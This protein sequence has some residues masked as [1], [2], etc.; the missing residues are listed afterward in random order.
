MA[1]KRKDAAENIKLRQPDRSGPTDQTLLQLAQEQDLFR[2]A[3]QQ[4]AQIRKTKIKTK[5]RKSGAEN[6][7]DDDDDDED[8]QDA[9]GL[10]PIAERIMDSVLWTVSLAMLHFT[11][12]V[13]V[14][15]QYAVQ[16]SWSAVSTR[17]V[18][19]FFAIYQNALRQAIFFVASIAAGCYLI[20]ISNKYDYLAVMKQAPPL[21]CL[22]VWSV[23]ELD[24]PFAVLSLACAALFLWQGG[25][26]FK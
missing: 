16:I 8:D 26:D 10:S 19:A 13:L 22:W 17:A 5:A 12:D 25:Y 4:E 15:N 14:Q 24:L 3:Q 20:H 11:L 9:P 23:I 6:D 21:G 7:D 2:R 18:Q 1:R